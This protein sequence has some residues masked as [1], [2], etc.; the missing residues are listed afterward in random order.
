MIAPFRI[1]LGCLVRMTCLT[2]AIGALMAQRAGG[3]EAAP[4]PAQDLVAPVPPEVLAA[5][6]ALRE[7]DRFLD[8]HPV[9]EDDLRLNPSFVGNEDYLKKNPELRGFL[10]TNPSVHDALK[11]YSHYFVYRALLRQVSL[12]VRYSDIAALNEVF[13]SEPALERALART[14]EAILDP[15]F[16]HVHPALRATL[17]SHPKLAEAYLTTGKGSAK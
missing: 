10:S 17:A 14:P 2:L 1:P 4:T 11:R 15:V 16:L 13:Q 9:V 3:A 7:F 5:R 12:P 6:H 8:H